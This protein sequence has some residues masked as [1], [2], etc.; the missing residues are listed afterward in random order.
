M[1]DYDKKY[2]F[3]CGYEQGE[4][5]C[6]GVHEFKIDDD[7]I[8][9]LVYRMLWV[10]DLKFDKYFLSETIEK[11]FDYVD[12]LYLK[13]ETEPVFSHFSKIDIKAEI[14][15]GFTQKVFGDYDNKSKSI[16]TNTLGD[17]HTYLITKDKENQYM[18]V[19]TSQMIA[20]SEVFEGS[21]ILT[22]LKMNDYEKAKIEYN[23][24]I[25]NQ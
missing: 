13:N 12:E 3:K 19:H 1:R 2:I 6:N 16:A 14:L 17:N 23:N 7:F 11:L 24:F 25:L 8:E 9:Y 4:S 10:Y 21:T 15:C 18:L 22:V 5:H 20:T